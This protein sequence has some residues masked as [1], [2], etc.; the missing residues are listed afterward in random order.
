[1]YQKLK[2]WTRRLWDFL[3]KMEGRYFRGTCKMWLPRCA[4]KTSMANALG[5]RLRCAPITWKKREKEKKKKKNNW[6]GV[7][8][9]NFQLNLS[10]FAL[11]LSYSISEFWKKH[12]PLSLWVLSCLNLSISFI[13]ISVSTNF[14][15]TSKNSKHSR[16][17]I[18]PFSF[19]Y[20]EVKTHK[21]SYFFRTNEYSFSQKLWHCYF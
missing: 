7:L 15:H 21:C 16:L 12:Y 20:T 14:K 3:D 11:P 2:T 4:S 8:M 5:L 9:S 1:M 10:P 17:K 18:L 19:S 13:W 6:V